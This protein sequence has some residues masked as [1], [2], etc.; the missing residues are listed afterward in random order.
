MLHC[1][2]LSQEVAAD[3]I[4]IRGERLVLAELVDQRLFD[5][6]F[7]ADLKQ[8][9]VNAK[10]FQHLDVSHWFNPLLLE[11][12]YEEFDLFP[13]ADIRPLNTKRER[14][15][16]SQS[17]AFGPATN[18]YFSIV[19]GGWFVELLSSLS[20]V[21]G[22]VS[23]SGMYGGGLHESRN[24]G[25]FAIHRDFDRHPHTALYNEMVFITYLNKGWQSSWLGALELWDA[26][27]AACV[28]MVQ[29]EFG[30][31]VLMRHGP[32][33][34]HGHATP[35]N[36]PPGQVRRSLA[37]YYYSS[38]LGFADQWHQPTTFLQNDSMD[39]LKLVLKGVTPPVL[40]R[41]LKSIVM[42]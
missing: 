5:P 18:L 41:L 6:Q 34:Y 32:G 7:C 27:A 25:R 39:K 13:T 26:S 24:G 37:T 40:W 9:L 30:G 12:V 1:N 38:R 42:R 29:P 35:L 4:T 2:V 11:L 15:Y 22:L 31:S 19:N 21:D 8:S 23:D 3:Y 17:M 20:G 10:P 16:R 33:S 14:T 36:M 28:K